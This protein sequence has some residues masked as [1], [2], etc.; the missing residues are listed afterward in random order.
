MKKT[1]P[2]LFFFIFLSIIFITVISGSGCANIIPPT[3][4]PKDTLPPKLISAVPKNPTVRFTGK[5]IVFTFDEYVEVKDKDQNLIVNPVPKSTP[6]VDYKLRVVTV[7]L[8]DTLQANTTYSINFGKAIRDV[9]EGNILK[10]FTYVF[11]TGPAIDSMVFSGRVTVAVTGKPDSTLSVVLH[12][13]LSD[14]AISKNRPRYVTK[15]DTSGYFTFR[16]IAPGTYAIYALKDESGSKIYSSKSQLFAFSDTPIVVKPDYRP[17]ELFAYVEE[18]DTKPVKKSGS[19][20]AASTPKQ[21]TKGKDKRLQ[22]QTNISAGQFDILDTLRFEFAAPLKNFDST[23]FMFTD[24]QYKVISSYH[25]TWDS[26]NKKLAFF[27][28]WLPDTK[29]NFIINKEFAEDTLGRQLLKNDTIPFHTRRES[30]YA[31]VHLRFRNLDIKRHPV[32]QF[33]QGETIKYSYKFV[34]REFNM[35]LFKPGEYDI[36][37]LYDDNQNGIWDAGD[38]KTHKQPEKVQAIRINT[39]K[40]KLVLRPNWEN[41]IDFTL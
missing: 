13:D 2:L 36:R 32:L 20:N 3:G 38:F 14:T 24:D 10:N 5:T 37:I 17:V 23:Q 4:G 34:N 9:N 26:T 27:Y 33:V 41:R 25:M 6:T 22:F 40:H 39:T 30:E 29:Y 1:F 8:K 12:R 7:K 11:S 35:M 19:A 15:V 28:K 18:V 21:P 31:E 16:N